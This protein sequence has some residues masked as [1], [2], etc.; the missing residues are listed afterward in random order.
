[1]PAA[2]QEELIDRSAALVWTE[3]SVD[4]PDQRTDL[5][6]VA[7]VNAGDA[8][9]FD[10]LYFRHRGWVVNLAYRFTADR[11]LALDVLQET[12]LYLARKF[13][14]FA[15]SCQLRSFLY[16]AVKNLSLN[17]LARAERFR[18]GDELFAALEAPQAAP[19][20]GDALRSALARLPAEQRETVA[21]R[22]IEGMDLAEIAHALEIPLGT[23]KSRLHHAL[24]A[25][26]HNP[27]LRE[28]FD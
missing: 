14:G 3:A 9:A 2:F 19:A 8:D 4:A 24:A 26:R 17:A 27:Q 13:P 18:P 20:D 6:L 10:S 15:L 12:F 1:M 16:P 23:V 7:A 28:Y 25:L 22:F 11:D 5:E 21:L